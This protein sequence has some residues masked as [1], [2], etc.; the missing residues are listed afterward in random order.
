MP[1][2]ASAGIPQP[3][4]LEKVLCIDDSLTSDEAMQAFLKRGKKQR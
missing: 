3:R 4:R 1:I 2:G